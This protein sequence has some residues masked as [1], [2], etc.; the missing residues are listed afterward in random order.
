MVQ[1]AT[2]PVRSATQTNCGN[3]TIT[4]ENAHSGRFQPPPHT[5]TQLHVPGVLMSTVLYVCVC[6][7]LPLDH[8][9]AAEDL[10]QKYNRVNFIL[11]DRC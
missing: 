1:V 7:T 11:H 8:P 5:H 9:G 10:T 6:K 4:D 3:C 2:P